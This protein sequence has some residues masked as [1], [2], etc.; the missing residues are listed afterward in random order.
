M[1]WRKRKRIFKHSNSWLRRNGSNKSMDVMVRLFH[2]PK[3][4]FGCGG[5]RKKE[6]KR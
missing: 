1:N 6:T 5:L 4:I 2:Y 3:P